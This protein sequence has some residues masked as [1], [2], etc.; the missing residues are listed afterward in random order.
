MFFFDFTH[1]GSPANSSVVIAIKFSEPSYSKPKKK[2]SS[3]PKKVNPEQITEEISKE[4]KVMTSEHITK[5]IAIKKKE[6]SP[7]KKKEEKKEKKPSKKTLSA[8]DK[9]MNSKEVGKGDSKGS[10]IVDKDNIGDNF[11]SSNFNKTSGKNYGNYQ[12]GDRAPLSRPM[13][14]YDCDEEGKVI[15]KILVNSQG[16]VTHA[17]PGVKGSTTLS[18]CLLKRAEEAALKT[19]FSKDK[20]NTGQNQEGRIIYNFTI[21]E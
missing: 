13:P 14:N 11:D 3:S 12:L 6:I 20:K 2:T 7:K 9:I 21:S 4:E 17:D 16:V 5:D 8:I 15:V 1:Q 19:L 18:P 10:D